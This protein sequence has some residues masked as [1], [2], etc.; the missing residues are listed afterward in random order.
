MSLVKYEVDGEI[1][2]VTINRPEI[3][4]PVDQEPR[5]R[6][7]SLSGALTRTTSSP[8]RS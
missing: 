2:V 8:S 6:W 4:N 3:R 1:V 5:P 7:P